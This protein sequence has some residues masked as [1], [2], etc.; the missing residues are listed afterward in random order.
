MNIKFG[1]KSKTLKNLSNH[2]KNGIIL[3]LLSFTVLE[4]GKNGEKIIHDI[5][6]KFPETK[7]IIRSSAI[8]EDTL[9]HSNAGKY[10]SVQNILS[11][12]KIELKEAI[13]KVIGS[14]K[15]GFPGDEILVQPMLT[16]IKICGVAFTADLDTFAPYYII[17]YDES[18]KSDAVTGGQGHKL[19]TYIHFK[20]SPIHCDNANI[21]NLIVCLKELETL[22]NCEFLDVEFAFDKNDK[23]YIFQARPIAKTGKVD[24]SRL[25][26]K[27]S[28][29]KIY[30]KVKK[31]MIPHPNL[32]GSKSAFGVM[33]DWNPAE[34]IG[35]KPNHLSLTL[36]KEL[37]TDNIWAYQRDNYGYRN[38]R[39]HPLMVSFL[40]VPFIDVRV[41]F[42][43]FV[44]K[45]LNEKIAQKLVDFYLKKIESTPSHHDKVEFEIVYSCYS[46]NLPEKL[47]ELKDY[48]FNDNEIKRIEFCLLELTNNIIN[49]DHGLYKQ[50]LNKIEILKQKYDSIVSSDLALIDKIYWLIEDCKRYGTL[51][52]AGIAR[53][54]FIAT[55]IFKSFIDAGIITVNE[56]NLYMGS[57]NTITKQMNYDLQLYSTNK[58]SKKNFLLKYGH[59]RP[60]TYDITSLRYDENFNKYFTRKID[61]YQPMNEFRLNKKQ[62][63]KIN[64]QISEAGITINAEALLSFIKESIE[65]REYAKFIFTKSLSQAILLINEYGLKLGIDRNDLAFLD[66]K[67]ILNLYATVGYKDAKNFLI[68]DIVK[69]KEAYEYTKIIKFPALI[70][71]PDDVY[72]FYVS[73]EEPTY[74]T[75]NVVKAGILQER[76]L[77]SKHPSGLIVFIKSADP[78]YDFL[79]TKNIAGLITQ[80]GGANS[81]MAVRCAELGIPAVIGAGEKKFNDW[82][83]ANVIEINALNKQ[84]RIV[85]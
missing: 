53:A 74:I 58:L 48:G 24:Y 63:E 49:P 76:D 80:F 12:N 43:S 79:F 33:P 1:T 22:L 36:Y 46:L 75:L 9:Q 25:N 27:D 68:E 78:G 64:H 17:N 28:L 16:D 56:Y 26:L 65:G 70:T 2:I 85:S 82:S 67:T 7:L 81:H 32:L 50:D 3:P 31:L 57:L 8:S 5:A 29:F 4:Y 11:S 41:D 61:N 52:F 15:G 44:P 14:Y 18:G 54:A 10:L 6:K 45:H 47:K 69:N 73:S 59:L 72:K 40:G 71:K 66:I 42:N 77:S 19:Y 13:D 35:L 51:P 62:I 55:Q 60:G 38:L 20:E 83:K 39:S 84:V 23:L 21:N 37:I 34:I 30:K